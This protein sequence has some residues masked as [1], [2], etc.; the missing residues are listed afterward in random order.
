MRLFSSFH[1]NPNIHY[2]KSLNTAW[3]CFTLVPR[4]AGVIIS[5]VIPPVCLTRLNRSTNLDEIYNEEPLF[6]EK[7]QRLLFTASTIYTLAEPRAKV[8]NNIYIRPLLN[9]CM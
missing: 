8:I 2:M 4:R 7:G 3:G 5:K 6:L 9:Y 1:K